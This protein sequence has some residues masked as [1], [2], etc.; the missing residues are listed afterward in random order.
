MRLVRTDLVTD[1]EFNLNNYHS[2]FLSTDSFLR[3][4]GVVVVQ[5]KPHPDATVVE[6][7]ILRPLEI[8]YSLLLTAVKCHSAAKE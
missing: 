5:V 4:K 1:F 6:P 8:I 3:A 2:N 7:H